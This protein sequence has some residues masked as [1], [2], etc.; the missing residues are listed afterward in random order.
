MRILWL[1]PSLPSPTTGNRARQFNLIKQLSCEHQFTVLSFV[2]DFEAGFL[3]LLRDYCT[4]LA[5]VPLP[6]Y[7]PLSLWRNRFYSWARLLFDPRP[8]H[9]LTYPVSRLRAELLRI[10][11]NHA[12]DLVHIETLSPTSLIGRDWASRTLLVEQNI[13]STIQARRFSLER[14]PVRKYREWVEWRKLLRYETAQLRR[15]PAVITVSDTDA[16]E[17]RKLAPKTSVSVV[18]NGVDVDWFTPPADAP[19]RQG[20][21]FVGTMDY[22][23]NVDAAL[24]FCREIWPHLRQA[25]PELNLTIAGARP[26]PEVQALGK[27]PGVKVTGFVEDMRPYFWNSA[28]CVVPLRNGGGTRLKILEAMAAE[29]PVISTTIGAEGLKVTDGENILLADDPQ[30]FV[31][32]ICRTINSPS[33]YKWMQ[34]KGRSLVE[35]EYEWSRLAQELD[36]VYEALMENL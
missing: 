20:L 10:L 22:A 25:I 35:S 17:C 8:T 5:T 11:S 1:T 15:F 30:Q 21:L 28:V 24:Y 32:S 3:S 18:P 4:D 12:F 36:Q 7:Q 9:I 19:A 13:E 6:L 29:L 26:A 34:I 16:A 2:T 27:L 33:Q 14:R 31:E 23:P